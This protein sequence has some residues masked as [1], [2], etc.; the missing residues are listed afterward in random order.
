MEM[1]RQLRG[2]LCSIKQFDFIIT[3]S[4][5]EH[6]FSNTV[7]LSKMLQGENADLIEAVKEASMVINVLNTERNDPSVWKELYE[8]GKQLAANVDNTQQHRVSRDFKQ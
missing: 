5:T 8:R 7:S 2:C 1:G 6:V 4:A 3:L